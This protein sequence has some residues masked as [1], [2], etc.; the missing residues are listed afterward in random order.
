MNVPSCLWQF[1]NTLISEHTFMT[2]MLYRVN[3]RKLSGFQLTDWGAFVHWTKVLRRRFYFL[4]IQFYVILFSTKK[5]I[6]HLW[7]DLSKWPET[8]WGMDQSC[9][10][11]IIR[12]C[13]RFLFLIE[14]VFFSISFKEPNGP[15]ILT[16]NFK[17]DSYRLYFKESAALLF[18]RVL[19]NRHTFVLLLITAYCHC[20]FT[21]LC[22]Y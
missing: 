10:L 21:C 13:H 6:S 19:K 4:C 3:H 22:C 17:Y 7:N 8:S 5:R 11:S 12:L 15:L 16:L 9:L 2:F 20:W 18:S 14:Q 1:I